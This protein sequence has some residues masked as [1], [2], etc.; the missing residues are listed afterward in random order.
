[1]PYYDKDQIAKAR[2]MDLLTYLRLYDPGELVKVSGENYSTRTHDS[3]SISHGKWMWWSRGF[4][5]ASAL[6]YLVKVRGHPF[7]EAVGKILNEESSGSPI[8]VQQREETKVKKLLLPE[9]NDSNDVVI[10]YLT[11]RGIDRGLV[12]ECIAKGMIYESLP[13]HNCIF[14]GFDDEAEARY[15]SFRASKPERIMGDTAGSDKRYSFCIKGTT[16]IVHVFESAID[17]LSFVTLE[18]LREGIAPRDNLL[19]L[20]GVYQPSADPARFKIPL[21]LSRFLGANKNIYEIVLHLDRDR[22]GSSMSMALSRALGDGY[23][24]RDEPPKFG[25]DMNDELMHVRQK[26]KEREVK[27]K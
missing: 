4:G 14:L 25:K 16:G 12:E 11:G 24:I 8:F 17:L 15:A 19:S 5:G 13:Y 2:E 1:M 6:D 18:K 21:A 20:A 7:T 23:Q 10:G 3:M 9:K 27:R 26:L 22:I